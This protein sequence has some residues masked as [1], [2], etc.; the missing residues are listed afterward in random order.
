M[1]LY[2]CRSFWNYWGCCRLLRIFFE[3]SRGLC[4]LENPFGIVGDTLYTLVPL[5]MCELRIVV[6]TVLKQS[7]EMFLC[8]GLECHVKYTIRCWINSWVCD[9]E[10]PVWSQWLNFWPV[11]WPSVNF[12][13]ETAQK[14]ECSEVSTIREQSAKGLTLMVTAPGQGSFT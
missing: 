8:S 11:G 13:W 10:E 12:P 2:S 4:T 5:G 6:G 1:T 3:L 9:C 7:F 14:M